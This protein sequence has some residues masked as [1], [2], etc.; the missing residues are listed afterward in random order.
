MCA[1]VHTQKERGEILDTPAREISFLS[2]PIRKTTLLKWRFAQQFY[3]QVLPG[4]SELGCQEG[5]SDDYLRPCTAL[6]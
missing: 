1:L 5:L 2:C 6:H 3:S 4:V